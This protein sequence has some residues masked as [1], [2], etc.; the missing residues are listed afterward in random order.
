[1]RNVRSGAKDWH[2]VAYR[3]TDDCGSNDSGTY[4]KI[5]D[6]ESSAYN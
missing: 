4:D 1:L 5:S 3:I 2:V 6:D